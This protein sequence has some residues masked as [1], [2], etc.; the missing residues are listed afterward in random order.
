MSPTKRVP[1]PNAAER[2]RR[3]Q[4]IDEW[5]EANGWICPGYGVPAHPV[6][7]GKLQ[8]DHVTPRIDGGETGSLRALCGPCNGRHAIERRWGPARKLDPWKK[9]DQKA[10][11]KLLR[12]GRW[13]EGTV[14][15][16]KPKW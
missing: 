9:S 15:E 11:Y 2:R 13:P 4:C 8:A 10:I 3:K 16:R 1:P 6:E 7:P 5:V 12:E 14:Y